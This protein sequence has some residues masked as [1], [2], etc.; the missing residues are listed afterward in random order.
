MAEVLGAISAVVSLIEVSIKIYD[1]ARKDIKLPETFDAVR[2]QL[3]VILD[4]LTKCKSHLE[5]RADSLAENVCEALEKIIESCEDEVTKLK[6]IFEK[7]ITGDGDS[8]KKRYWKLVKRLGKGNKVEEL[9]ESITKQVQLLVNHN[10]VRSGNQQQNAQLQEILREMK[11]IES[12]EEEH[13]GI[14]ISNGDGTQTNNINRDGGNLHNHTGTYANSGHVGSQTFNIVTRQKKNFSFRPPVGDCL[15][16]APF[17]APELFVGRC[18][19]IVEIAQALN[20]AQKVHN[21]RRLVLGGMGGAGKTRLAI[22]YAKS[23]AASYTSMFWLNATSEASLKDSFRLIA[24]LIFNAQD[25]R[26]LK[27]EGIVELVHRWLSDSANAGA[28]LIYDNYDDPS[29]Y[30]INNYYPPCSQGSI[31]VTTRVPA[32]VAGLVLDVKP[33]QDINDSL[34]IL[35]TRSKRENVQSDPDAT[36]LAKRLNG[37]PLALATAGTYLQRSNFTF[38]RYLE[39]YEKRWNIH[40]SNP[41]QLQDY[42]EHTLFTAWNLSYAQLETNSPLAA[43]LLKLL[44]YFGNENL[45][46]ELFQDG[47][48]ESSPRWLLEVVPDEVTFHGVVA[49]LTE[50]YFLEGHLTS[51]S[52]SMHNCVHDWTLAVLNKGIDMESYWFALDCVHATIDAF[53]RYDFERIIFARSAGHATRLVEQRFLKNDIAHDSTPDQITKLS[54]VAQLLHHQSQMAAAE[55]MYQRALAGYEEILGPKHEFTLNAVHNIGRLYRDQDKPDKAEEM[56]QRALAGYEETLG[57]NH[58]ST[59]TAVHNIGVLYYDQGKPD[60][61]EEMYQRALAAYK[62]ILGPNHQS[63]LTAVHNIGLLYRDQ[64]KPDK[65]EEMYQWA[66]AGYEEMLGPNHQLTLNAV[67][68]IGLLYYDQGKPDK[69]EEMY[70]RALAGYEEILGPNH[71]S[72]L[73]AVDSISILYHDQ[74]KLDKA[75]EMYQWA[76][77]GYEEMLGPNHQSTLIAVHNIGLLYYIQGKPDKAEEMYQRALAGYEEILGPKHKSTLQ[78]FKNLDGL[79]RAQ[80]KLDKTIRMSKQ[81]RL[82]DRLRLLGSYIGL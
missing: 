2:H 5:R 72:T 79:L 67:H 12:S 39:E 44:A 56:Y 64:G 51:K 73:N 81:R 26:P 74:G 65:A 75:E 63:T 69:A 10:S 66:L 15:G 46:Y 8:W 34:A 7:M 33:F 13:T 16:Q 14:Y 37:L 19:E 57:P 42:R 17:L 54:H 18:S 27:S 40:P 35:Q 49:F 6:N 41:T 25:P 82:R 30:D 80:G 45:W 28:L 43:K 48:S 31:L 4:I 32:Q 1:G 38:A 60:K 24:N 55:Q 29:Q 62:A 20:P 50:Y 11:S 59:L 68:S 61:A 22:A 78:V 21:Q 47:I 58:Q 52:W 53:D 3:P 70:Q 76:L 71:Q 9:M 77:A 36:R 23:H